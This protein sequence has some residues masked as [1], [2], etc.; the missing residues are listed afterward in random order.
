MRG[1][2]DHQP[3]TVTQ[4]EQVVPAKIGSRPQLVP[5]VDQD[6]RIRQKKTDFIVVASTRLQSGLEE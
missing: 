5:E 6:L 3:Q 2:H 4:K 1:G